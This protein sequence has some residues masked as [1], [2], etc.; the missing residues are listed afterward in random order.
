MVSYLDDLE[1]NSN[2]EKAEAEVKQLEHLILVS[3]KYTRTVDM[4]KE[5]VENLI[6]TYEFIILVLLEY[7]VDIKKIIEI[8]ESVNQKCQTVKE[9]IKL[10]GIGEHIDLYL[11]MRRILK[12]DY[13]SINE[14][15]RHVAMKNIIDDK[16]MIINI[17]TVTEHYNEIKELFKRVEELVQK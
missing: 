4:L 14:F 7:L 6:E 12:T 17:D 8:P 5:V 9:N 10:G 1:L 13:I 3:L 15:R 11:R 2:I 16:E